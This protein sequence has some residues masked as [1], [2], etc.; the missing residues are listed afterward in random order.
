[1]DNFLDRYQAP[2]L[3]QDQIFDLIS[4]ISPKAIETVI[5]S[6]PITKSPGPEGF[7]PE[8]YQTTYN[9][10]TQTILKMPTRSC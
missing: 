9:Y 6:L 3:N 8:F 7:S 5:I 10:L 2:K 4:P 1:M